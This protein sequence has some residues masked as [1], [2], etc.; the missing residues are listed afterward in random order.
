LN[1][2]DEILK[3]SGVDWRFAV[4][5]KWI[6][7][8][9]KSD[10]MAFILELV[11]LGLTQDAV[12]AISKKAKHNI[13]VDLKVLQ[14]AVC[15]A[16]SG[17]TLNDDEIAVRGRFNDSISARLDASFE[18]AD[19]LYRN[20][21]KLVASGVAIV[22]SIWAGGLLAKAQ[23]MEFFTYGGIWKAIM[24]GVLAVPLAPIAKDLA[25]TLQAAAKALKPSQ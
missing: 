13:P 11:R 10:Q 20:I 12:E 16:R 22:L 8:V 9:K 6:N 3:A 15:K 19:Q 2:Y 24:I 23:G 17:A 5:A 21:C 25:S 18:A 7:G 14:S 4:R 1:D